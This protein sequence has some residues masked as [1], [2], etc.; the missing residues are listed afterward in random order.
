MEPFVVD[1][2]TE[3]DIAYM[4]SLAAKE[5]WAPG[6][7]DAKPFYA[8][9]PHGFF[10][11]KLNGKPIGCISNV[12]YGSDFAFLGLYIVEKAFRKQGY[13][14]RLWNH[15]MEY[16]KGRSI[17]LDGVLQ[18]Q[19]NYKKSGFNLSYKNIRYEIRS[20]STLSPDT[21]AL[22]AVSFRELCSY[23]AHVFGINRENFLQQWIA[24]PNL[25][26]ALL[27]KEKIIQGYGVIRECKDVYKVGPLFAES[28]TA[29]CTIFDSLQSYA[30]DTPIYLDV[31][32]C[33]PLALQL[34]QKYSGKKVFETARM[35]T[36]T[37]PS[38]PLN[39]TFGITSFELG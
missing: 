6:L 21:L 7:F 27:L 38:A 36:G 32:E 22:D 10:I 29:A 39:K 35:Y 34:A 11:G 4:L 5:G 16:A 33:N 3:K 37:T 1:K 2:A 14:M 24:M 9:D 19:H 12:C 13:G 8:Q 30:G 17:G 23:D 26:G 20:N 15:A 31:A 25:K 18:Q 28:F